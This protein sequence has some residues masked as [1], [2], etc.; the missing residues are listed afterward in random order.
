MLSSHAT[1]FSPKNLHD[2]ICFDSEALSQFDIAFM[3]LTLL[4]SHACGR[5]NVVP[6]VD[7]GV[8]KAKLHVGLQWQ[9]LP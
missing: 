6:W 9:L 2:S 4:D 7:P 3:I 5:H 1:T 8:R